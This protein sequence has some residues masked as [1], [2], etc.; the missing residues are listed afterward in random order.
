VS[1]LAARLLSRVDRPGLVDLA[2]EW[3]ELVHE[4]LSR[5]LIGLPL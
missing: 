3:V 2:V 1:A 5:P 4:G